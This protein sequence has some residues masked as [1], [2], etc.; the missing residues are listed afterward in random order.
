M[1][2]REPKRCPVIAHIPLSGRTVVHL[3]TG[4][5]WRRDYLYLDRGS[6]SPV[7]VFDVTHPAALKETGIPAIPSPDVRDIT[8]WWGVRCWSRP[9]LQA[10][11]PQVVTIMSF[12]DSAHPRVVQKF[13]GI[14][15]ILK[16][17][18]RGLLYLVDPDGLWVLRLVPATEV[19]LEKEFEY[20]VR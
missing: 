20:Y 15:A 1:Q 19:E 18:S 3:T 12:G 7:A 16:D 13:S 14:T 10:S 2:K 6:G 8:A 5:H 11:G 17:D 4:T 9:P